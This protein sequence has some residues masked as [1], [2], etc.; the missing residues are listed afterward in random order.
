MTPSIL[1]EKQL[2][3]QIVPS[4]APSSFDHGDLEH[5]EIDKKMERKIMLR[6]DFILLPTIG[7]LYM[8]VSTCNPSKPGL[9]ANECVQ[10]FLDR[11]NIANAKIEGLEAGLNMPSNG[12]NTALWIFYI[13]FVIAEVP[14]NLI[15]NM[16][17][18]APNYFLGGMTCMLGM[19][20][21]QFRL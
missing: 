16:G 20:L 12:Y 2:N 1:E 4:S 19:W 10:M 8:I 18:I 6:R 13:P 5:V 17:K 3:E 9:Q 15:L 14:S 7:L 11:T 21:A